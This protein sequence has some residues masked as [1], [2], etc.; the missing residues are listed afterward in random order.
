[1]EASR[2]WICG[3]LKKKRKNW[4]TRKQEIFDK[5]DGLC[6][7]CSEKLSFPHRKV[8]EHKD[9]WEIEH[10]IELAHC[11]G[12]EK[13][14]RFVNLFPAH[15][16]CNG[17][18]V[19]QG[20]YNHDLVGVFDD[21]GARWPRGFKPHP[22]LLVYLNFTTAIRTCQEVQEGVELEDGLMRVGSLLIPP[23]DIHVDYTSKLTGG[24]GVVRKG[25][26]KGQDVA[27]KTPKEASMRKHIVS[28]AKFLS[29]I[30]H[31]NVVCLHGVTLLDG[32][33]SLVM[34]WVP[35]TLT[36]PPEGRWDPL[37]VSRG[38]VAGLRYLH[39]QGIIHRDLKPGNVLVTLDGTTGKLCDFGIA[40]PV[41]D[42]MTAGSGTA[43]FRAPEVSRGEGLYDLR[44]DIFSLGHTLHAISSCYEDDDRELPQK[45]TLL[46]GQCTKRQVDLRPSLADVQK[47]LAKMDYVT[48]RLQPAPQLQ[49]AV[50]PQPA[51]QPQPAVQPQPVPQLQPALQPVFISSARS[52]TYHKRLGCY[53][54]RVI[55]QTTAGR[56]GCAFCG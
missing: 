14:D 44:A 47:R 43:Y 56:K 33:F 23:E 49:P 13:Y 24:H 7:H 27:I 16:E 52:K 51:P 11:P 6:C 40:R 42:M 8:A 46:F 4:E 55:I 34:E 45:F 20:H 25:T 2:K 3:C 19:N 37:S 5:T 39:D 22:K 9:A 38:L 31:P 18:H 53:G 50:Q 30:K 17:H 1:M 10:Y 28:E 29:K 35:H 21:K 12:H 36:N 48:V 26:W 54:A 41:S 15:V 32:Q